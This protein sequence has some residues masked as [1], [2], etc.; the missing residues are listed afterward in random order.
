MLKTI[1]VSPCDPS[2]FIC[3]RLTEYEYVERYYPVQMWSGN[4]KYLDEIKLLL[5]SAIR[6]NNNHQAFLHK[7][8]IIFS[9]GNRLEAV[10][11]L[12]E[13]GWDNPGL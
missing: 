11:I 3:D 10:K 6:I 9:K 12:K 1:Y 2:L 13:G 7:A 5:D 4:Q 8:E